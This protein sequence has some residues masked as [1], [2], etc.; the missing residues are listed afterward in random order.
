MKPRQSEQPRLSLPSGAAVR[1][2][3][4][5][6]GE[7]G[8]ASVVYVHGFGG[9]RGA[10]KAAAL[11]AACARRGWTF[12]AFDF[13]GHGD[14]DGS[15]L[16]LR[17]SGLQ[18]DLETVRAYLA[19]RGVGRLFL[20]GSSMGG[21]AS[22]WFARRHPEVVPAMVG[23]APSFDFLGAK[24]AR[25]SNAGREM[26][27]H[28][29]R[30]RVRNEYVDVEIGYGLMEEEDVFRVEDLS[31]GWVT[32]LLIYHG[33]RDDVVPYADSLAFMERTAFPD[34]ELRLLKDG[35][36]RLQNH[37]HEIAEA[38]CGFFAR[39]WDRPGA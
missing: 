13:R 7:P 31:E 28:T 25:L 3:L 37:E 1:G 6:N 10:T 38:T 26:W 22:A 32:P 12:A 9:S 20:A 39:W 17:G 30:L 15:M 16:D 33:L 14:S 23:L 34:V 4:S 5:F 29:G 11:E 27:R 24:W 19:T 18:H 21:W 2:T 35:D 8:T 36:H